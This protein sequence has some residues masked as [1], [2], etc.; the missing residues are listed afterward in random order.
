[1]FRQL[2]PLEGSAINSHIS[3]GLH[4]HP[5]PSTDPVV[6]PTS[7]PALKRADSSCTRKLKAILRDTYSHIDEISHQKKEKRKAL[8]YQQIVDNNKKFQD[9]ISTRLVKD[10]Q[11]IVNKDEI[12]D[13]AL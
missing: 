11:A 10:T 7:D 12:F 3:D 9:I 1:M 4:A 13:K 2:A 8:L 6:Q 5:S